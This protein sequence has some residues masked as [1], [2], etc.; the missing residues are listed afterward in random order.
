ME[1]TI[2]SY[3]VWDNLNGTYGIPPRMA[4]REFI[5]RARGEILEKSAKIVDES[6]VTEDGQE[7]LDQAKGR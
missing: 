6:C 4:T 1:V 3:R 2:Y 5:E 7:I